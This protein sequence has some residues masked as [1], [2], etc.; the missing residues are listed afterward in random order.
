MGKHILTSHDLSA[1]L[2]NLNPFFV[3][4][5]I[6]HQ[7]LFQFRYIVLHSQML[8]RD[9]TGAGKVPGIAKFKIIISQYLKRTRTCPGTKIR[10]MD[11]Q[12][13][14]GFSV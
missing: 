1:V 13:D 7:Q 9:Q 10:V 5:Q 4:F 8:S 3:V 2:S 11:T 14:P 12:V 6:I